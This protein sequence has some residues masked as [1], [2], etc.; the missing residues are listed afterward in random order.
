MSSVVA[1]VSSVAAIKQVTGEGKE[2]GREEGSP[3][4]G[5]VLFNLNS[6]S[7]AGREGRLPLG[8]IMH[9][10]LKNF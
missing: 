3:S 8:D 10:F 5:L 2:G 6:V 9:K 4:L 1:V 7:I